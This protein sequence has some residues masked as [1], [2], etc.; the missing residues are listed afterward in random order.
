AQPD[1]RRDLVDD[2]VQAR[3]PAVLITPARHIGSLRPIRGPALAGPAAPL[4]GP[5]R[6]GLPESVLVPG[7]HPAL[8]LVSLVRSGPSVGRRSLGRRHPWG[9]PPPAA[10][11]VGAR[12]RRASC[13]S[14]DTGSVRAPRYAFFERWTGHGKARRSKNPVRCGGSVPL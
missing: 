6:R 10:A 5:R 13:P 8:R 2:G 3:R 11:R 14:A 9:T 1:P 4:G 7:G 12:S